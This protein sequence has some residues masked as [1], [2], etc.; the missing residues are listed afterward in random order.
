MS[1]YYETADILVPPSSEAGTKPHRSTS[2]SLKSRVFTRKNLKSPPAQI[3]ALATET[4]KWSEVL[5]E[6]IDNSEL[7]RYER[8]V[9]STGPP[10][11]P[12][13]SP[14]SL[15]FSLP[16]P[17]AHP[18]VGLTPGPRFSS[19]QGRNCASPVAWIETSHR[20]AQGPAHF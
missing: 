5:K 4:C 20:A 19:F 1:L 9:V 2:G 17:A 6:I 10:C 12:S 11:L 16:S 15:T 18:C 7:L 13:T 14:F 3:F 8:K